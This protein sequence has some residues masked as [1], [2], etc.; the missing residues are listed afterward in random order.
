MENVTGEKR[1]GCNTGGS[2][3]PMQAGSPLML[4]A[5]CA[6]STTRLVTI[7]FLFVVV[8]VRRRCPPSR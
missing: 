1:Y 8:C 4:L 7:A 2:A 3:P 5:A 6:F